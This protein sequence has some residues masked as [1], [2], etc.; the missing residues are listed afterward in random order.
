MTKVQ[1]ENLGHDLD[2]SSNLF[3]NKFERHLNTNKQVHVFSFT[4]CKTH[5]FKL[6]FT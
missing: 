4:W 1:R 2:I 6:T 5:N 3:Q